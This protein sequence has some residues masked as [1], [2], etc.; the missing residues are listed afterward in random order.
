MSVIIILP[1]MQHHP[2]DQKS[3][4]SC[5]GDQQ[6]PYYL[7][8]RSRQIMKWGNGLDIDIPYFTGKLIQAC[9]GHCNV[10]TE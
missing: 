9:A 8:L 4:L 7:A 6:K 5:K 2:S 10:N 1:M 3:N